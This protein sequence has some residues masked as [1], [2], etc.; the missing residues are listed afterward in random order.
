MPSPTATPLFTNTPE[1]NT[2]VFTVTRQS[3]MERWQNVV[4]YSFNSPSRQQEIHFNIYTPPNYDQSD[5]RYPVLYFLHGSQGSHALFWNAISREVMAANGDAGGW[6]SQLIESGQIP[7]LIIVA[8][9][10]TDGGWGNTNETMVTQEL[11]QVID[12]N[13]RTIADGNGRSLAGFS[14]G[15]VGAEYYP[16]LYPEL[17]CNSILMAKSHM[18]E[19]VTLWHINQEAI[20]ASDLQIALVVGE[21]DMRAIK[22]TTAFE[23]LLTDLT[24]PYEL[25]TVPDVPHNFGQLYNQIG[26]W[27]L[28]FHTDCR[29]DA[30]N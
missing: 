2:A 4:E 29:Q 26:V 23:Q 16:S 22:A 14:M 28:Q 9:N 12:G 13:W 24:I 10:D 1:P 19:E 5:E 30:G 21:L 27:A 17:Y 20:I 6:I 18:D 25:Q 8:P 15:A 11:V 7:P 3:R